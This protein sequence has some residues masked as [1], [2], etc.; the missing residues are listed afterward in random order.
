MFGLTFDVGHNF[1]KKGMD[2]P[3]IMGRKE[4]LF[5]MH[6]HDVKDGNKDHQALGTGDLDIRKYIS[7][8]QERELS[9]VV[10]AKTIAGLRQSA[11]WLDRN[12]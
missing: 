2:E 5:H 9:V 8:A 11:L 7:L 1:C 4:K 12:L 3:V 10:E 6:L